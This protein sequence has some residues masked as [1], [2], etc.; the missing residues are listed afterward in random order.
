MNVDQ[1]MAFERQLRE[2]AASVGVEVTL[3]EVVAT[4]D[5]GHRVTVAH[6]FDRVGVRWCAEHRSVVD[7]D[8]DG[9]DHGDRWHPCDVRALV[10]RPAVVS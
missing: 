9:C 3:L 10:A 1:V 6:G 5:E 4:V 7:W 8:A 2:L